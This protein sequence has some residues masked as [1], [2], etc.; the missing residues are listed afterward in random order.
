MKKDDMIKHLVEDGDFTKK[1]LTKKKVADI[2]E[3]FDTTF[4]VEYE[5][6]D[7]SKG[8]EYSD[9]YVE[10][11]SIERTLMEN[12]GIDANEVMKEAEEFE[13]KKVEE[14]IVEIDISKLS[15]VERR[16]YARTGQLPP[17]TYNRYTRFDDED[18]K[19]EI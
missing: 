10:D 15:P 19:M 12:H 7:F 9:D 16:A 14:E 3:L 1:E 5:D 13:I 6:E 4:T 17:I 18:P 11:P 8:L 2:Q